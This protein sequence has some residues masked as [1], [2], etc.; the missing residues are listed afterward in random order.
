MTARLLVGVDV[1]TTKVKAAAF[2]LGGELSGQAQ[3]AYPLHRPAPD[4]AEQDADDWWRATVATLARLGEQVDLSTC[5]G[6]GVC[7]QVNTH[8]F[9]GADG[10]PLAP[11]IT[12]GD[13]RCAEVAERMGE[14]IDASHLLARAQWAIEQEPELWERTR[15]LMSPKDYVNLR[16][17]GVA[18]SDAVS[19]IGLTG[20]DDAYLPTLEDLVEGVSAV[21]PPLAP[22]TDV[23]GPT[24]DAAAPLPAGVPVAVATMDA[25]GNLFGS[26]AVASGDGIEV[27]GT[28]EIVA[29]LSDRGAGAPGVVSFHPRDG[30]QVHAGPT[31]AGGDALR[32]L[33]EAFGSTPEAIL[34]LAARAPGGSSG[35]VFLPQ[36]LGER[37]PLWDSNLRGGFVNMGLQ[38]TQEHLCRAVLEGVAYSARHLRE[39]IEDAAALRPPSLTIS[40]GAAVSDLWC[41]IKADVHGLPLVRPRVLDTGVLGAALLGGVAA[42]ELEDVRD[43]ARTLVHPERTFEPEPEAH[44]RYDAL[45]AL[46]RATQQALTP[47]YAELARV[48]ATIE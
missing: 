45:F 26:G 23:L 11:A 12:W 47:V 38:H 30:V 37:A 32:W 13:Q 42:G 18:G 15:W 14:G 28:S 17:T 29:V 24:S 35:L 20:P 6:I 4:R 10:R 44:E 31:Q 34:E 9:V 16:L 1:G 41:Q 8:V 39:A 21:L 27:A 19:S 25:W 5:A 22:M 3:E 36:L 46:Y 2:D 43:G 7:S 33:A 40:G 48:R